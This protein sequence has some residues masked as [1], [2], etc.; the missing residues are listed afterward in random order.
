MLSIS[1]MGRGAE[2]YYLKL[3]QEDYYTRGTEPPGQWMG[4][5]AERLGLLGEVD[6]KDLRALVAGF[7]PRGKPLVQ[8]AG[9]ESHQAGWDLTFSA[10]KSVSVV[11]ALGDASTRK[12]VEE[13]HRLAVM[14]AIRYV[15]EEALLT[16]RGR[17]GKTLEAAMG[18]FAVFEHGTSRLQDPQLHSHALLLNV[19]LRHDGSTGAIQSKPV[20]EQK[21][22]LGALYRAELAARIEM[23]LGLRVEPDRTSFRVVGVPK[24]ICRFFSKRREQIERELEARGAQGPLESE[25]SALATRDRKRSLPRED[26]H[27]AWQAEGRA[28]GYEPLRSIAPEPERERAIDLREATRRLIDG[29]LEGDSTFRKT[30][31]LR[32]V[33]EAAQGTGLGTGEVRRAVDAELASERFE[34]LPTQRHQTYTTQEPPAIAGEILA[35]LAQSMD[36]AGLPCSAKAV[37]DAEHRF[38]FVRDEKNEA[39]RHITLG[40]GGIKILSGVA[41]SGKTSLLEAAREAWEADGYRVLG[42]AVTGRASRELQERSGIASRTVR[43]LLDGLGTTV[44][45]MAVHHAT[46]ILKEAFGRRGF[47][48]EVPRL[49]GRTVLVVDG[50]E[51][52]GARQMGA[53]VR[54]AQDAGA[55]LV[56]VGD[57][58]PPRAMAMASPFEAM[59]EALGGATLTHV[60]RQK[61]AWARQAVMDLQQGEARKAIEAFR[62]RGLLHLDSD[63]GD[64]K[65]RLAEDYVAT[66]RG[67]RLAVADSGKDARD[68]NR[69]I[70]NLRSE[71]S[72]LG[73]ATVYG[74]SGDALR[75]GDEVVL[76][77]RSKLYG[78]ENGDTAVVIG[79]SEDDRELTIRTKAGRKVTLPLSRYDQVELGYATTA[80]KAR[81]TS[82]EHAFVYAGHRTDARG[83]YDRLSLGVDGTRLYGLSGAAGFGAAVSAKIPGEVDPG[84]SL[85]ADR[86]PSLE[87]DSRRRGMDRR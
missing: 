42:A 47:K 8:S 63:P 55:K 78:I 59:A 77:R 9:R 26:L 56:L 67:G 58:G 29:M 84:L 5:G 82:V 21:M 87:L 28:L 3:A 80:A 69:R 64:V 65:Q 44:L 46:Q 45:D 60:V 51:G 34:R 70:Q 25:R 66:G 33:G 79:V 10:P 53:L 31:L 54:H 11:W 68:L 2:D 41:G 86:G 57:G 14:E 30:D 73:Q 61:E 23:N 76:G 37:A 7:D 15:E 75:T 36:H 83:L 40:E 18:A 22:A 38:G 27:L 72:E 74:A 1:K 81:G 52:L 17:G 71:R 39:L 35:R 32:G 85:E 16:R 48:K 50:A 6:P 24:E 12:A 43:S 20:Y 62:S 4:E 19:G 49:D 13:C